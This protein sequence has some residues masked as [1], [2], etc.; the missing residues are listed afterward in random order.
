MSP[1]AIVDNITDRV[2]VN[3]KVQRKAIREFILG[4]VFLFLQV[5]IS[6]ESN[7]LIR[8]VHLNRFE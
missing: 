4:R 1:R 3:I 8:Q 7:Y 6:N 2:F 5:R